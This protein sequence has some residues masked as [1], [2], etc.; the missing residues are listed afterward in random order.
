MSKY[1]K[2]PDPSRYQPQ[3]GY[4]L[5]PFPHHILF[6]IKS[7]IHSHLHLLVIQRFISKYLLPSS[8]LLISCIVL[9]SFVHSAPGSFLNIF[10]T[11]L[12]EEE[13]AY[14]FNLVYHGPGDRTFALSA[15]SQE[16]MEEWMK[17]IACASYDYMKV[18]VAELQKQVNE[19]TG[20]MALIV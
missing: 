12:S 7:S 2:V 11:E 8:Y 5:V 6:I 1:S 13:E 16:S 18:V 3:F 20:Y 17:A 10:S 4:Q 19:L 14:C 15:D 9:D